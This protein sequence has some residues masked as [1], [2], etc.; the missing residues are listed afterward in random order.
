M[1]DGKLYFGYAD[2]HKAVKRL[3]ERVVA[4]GYEPDVIV[5][6][7]SGGF[8]PARIMRTFLKRPILAVGIVLYDDEKGQGAEPRKSQWIDEAE[9]KVRG[10][11]VLIVDEV[12]DSRTTLQY[13]AEELAEH[14]PEEIAIAVIHNKRK[15]KEGTLPEAVTR[16]YRADDIDDRWV[17]YP[18]DAL[19]ID[20]Q[21][22]LAAEREGT[23]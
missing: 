4:S 23:P 15:P 5:A 19:D 9:E 3:A 21:E 7:G 13:C 8:I 10:K 6:I 17:C 11:R 2:I 14:C 1:P 18:W 16:Y 12:D 22:R 20:E